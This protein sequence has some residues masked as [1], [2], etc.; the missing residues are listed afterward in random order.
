[1]G[2]FAGDTVKGIINTEEKLGVS[3]KESGDLHDHSD[4]KLIKYN[5]ESVRLN[6]Q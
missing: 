4:K 3:Q 1:M 5:H 2:K 6:S